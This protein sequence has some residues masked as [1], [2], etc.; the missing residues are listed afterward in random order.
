[1]SERQIDDQLLAFFDTIRIGDPA[2]RQLWVDVIR[3][4]AHDG[5]ARNRA[6][7]NELLRQ[8]DQVNAKLQKLLDLRMD[9]EITADE[10]ASKRQE[11]YDRQSAVALQLQ[12]SDVDG[13]EIAELAVKAFELWG[14]QGQS[15]IS[16]KP[17]TVTYFG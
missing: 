6:H 7:E 10:Y 4:R 1:M 2:M 13:R 14:N 5:F 3:A 15:P 9:G 17:R 16:G 11:L 12:T 8:R